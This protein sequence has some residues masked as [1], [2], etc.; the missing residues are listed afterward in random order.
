MSASISFNT[1][2]L[3]KRLN[4]IEKVFLKQAAESALKQFSFDSRSIWL[5]R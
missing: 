5:M 4:Q 3:E 1:K 2:A